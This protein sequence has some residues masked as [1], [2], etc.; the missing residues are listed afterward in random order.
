[1]KRNRLT[2]KQRM[3]LQTFLKDK[4]VYTKDNNYIPN[5]K[6]QPFIQQLQELNIHVTKRQLKNAI[7][8]F[9]DKTE[10]NTR[11]HR[12]PT[13]PKHTPSVLKEVKTKIIQNQHTAQSMVM[14]RSDWDNLGIRTYCDNP[15]LLWCLRKFLQPSVTLFKNT[16]V[17]YWNEFTHMEDDTMMLL[18]SFLKR[19]QQVFSINVGETENVSMVGWNALLNAIKSFEINIVFVFIDIK[20][21]NAEF[22]RQIKQAC[23]MNRERL[24]KKKLLSECPWRFQSFRDKIQSYEND[25]NLVL[26]K[27]FLGAAPFA[28]TRFD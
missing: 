25:A 18:V 23:K 9:S 10:Q 7:K 6:L 2:Q 5:Q 3:E 11:S 26:G 20:N 1:M 21:T 27:T 19:N 8:Q 17:M 16:Y 4:I 24:E 28:W 12:I 13:N 22:I 15:T 14:K